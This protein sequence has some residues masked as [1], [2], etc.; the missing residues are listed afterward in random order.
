MRQLP[1]MK[2][3]LPPSGSKI[4]FNLLDNEYF[5]IPYIT[6]T[7]PNSTAGHQLLSQAKTKVWIVAINGED[8]IKAQGVLDKLNHHQT[9][10]S[11]HKIKIT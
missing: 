3:D 6:D 1:H 4:G 5:T 11:K 9:T 10:Q 7:I 8:T 2:I